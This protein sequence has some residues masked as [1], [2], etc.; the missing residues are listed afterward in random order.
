MD[1]GN[2]KTTQHEVND[3]IYYFFTCTYNIYI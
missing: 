3:I 2:K 1:K